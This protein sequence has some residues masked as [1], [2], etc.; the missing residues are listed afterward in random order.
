ME[1]ARAALRAYAHVRLQ[2]LAWSHTGNRYLRFRS[3]LELGP[4]MALQLRNRLLVLLTV[5]LYAPWAA[6]SARRMRAGAVAV[7][8]RIVPDEFVSV[9]AG[10][11]S[12][13]AADAADELLGLR[14]GW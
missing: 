9:I 5:G 1:D 2:N 6:A 12:Q 4:Y 13:L 3:N 10:R 14:I 7:V 11:P 8:S